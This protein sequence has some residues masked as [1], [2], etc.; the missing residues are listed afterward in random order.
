[1]PVTVIALTRATLVR[2]PRDAL[3]EA[4]R[5][6]PSLCEYLAHTLLDVDA[7]NARGGAV[8]VT[9]TVRSLVLPPDGVVFDYTER[10][11]VVLLELD[12]ERFSPPV[13]C[14]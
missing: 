5:H 1:M 6:A 3:A 14:S 9:V 8:D 4:M 11:P 10:S 7:P 12:G 2:T 13:S